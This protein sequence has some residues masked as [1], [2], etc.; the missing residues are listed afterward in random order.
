MNK[1]TDNK[2]ASVKLDSVTLIS[3]DKHCISPQ[4]FAPLSKWRKANWSDE[5]LSPEV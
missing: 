1:E 2:I 4:M 5:S 3:T